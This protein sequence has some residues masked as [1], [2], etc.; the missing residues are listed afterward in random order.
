MKL[1]NIAYTGAQAAQ[2]QLNTTAMNTANAYT[3][4]YSRQ[5]VEVSALGGYGMSAGSGVEVTGIRRISDQ[6]LVTQL[7][8]ANSENGYYSMGQQYVG[9]LEQIIGSESTGLGYGLDKFFA[10]LNSATTTPENRALREQV[11]NE[12]NAMA[13]RFNSI[14][15]F[16]NTQ[17]DSINSQR[18]ATLDSI[19][20]MSSNISEFN[21]QISELEAKG[22]NA[23]TLRDERD[24]MVNELSTM[25]DVRVNETSDGSYTVAL[26]DGQPL[27]SGRNA[28]TLKMGVDGNGQPALQLTFSGTT[29]GV[30]MSTGGQL[31]ALH[32]YE[33]GTLGEMQA[34]V[35]SMAKT[36]ADTFNDQL[37]QGYDLNGN[38]GK[39]LF[40]FDPNNPKG[41]LQ[42][43][44]ISS[45]ELAFSDVAGEN[46][47]GKN[48]QALIG[49]K[50]QTMN[51]DGLGNM[52][53]N[54]ASAAIV[55]KVGIASRQ[56]Q[57]ELR[58][59]SAV[60]FEAQSQRDGLSAVNLD[61]EAVNLLTYTK[62]YQSNLKVMATG[63]Q[64]FSDLLAL[65]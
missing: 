23:S 37:A 45:D 27:V 62:A 9:A 51:I 4:G 60:L 50:N 25:V 41:M 44:D 11:I 63:D 65:F 64:I 2:S 39:P 52:S 20:S 12:A 14:N 49:I 26:P 46:G 56:N 36:I 59:A 22:H 19:N 5:R 7:W 17:K 15:N 42:I 31:G 3:P 18:N 53:L 38:P 32:D 16:I 43:T 47:N 48:L 30:N 54:E 61:E 1:I 40:V 35:T 29:F 10:S 8:R 6:Y 58:A 28:S 21:R 33:V 57:V 24:Q 55:S 34:T 13:T